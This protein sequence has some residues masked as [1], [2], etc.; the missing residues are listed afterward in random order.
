MATLEVTRGAVATSGDYERYLEIDGRRYSHIVSP[1]TGRPVQG[2][3]GVSVFAEECVVAGSATTIAMLMEERGPAWL[4][5]VSLPHVWMDRDLHVGGT[6][7]SMAEQASPA[8][9]R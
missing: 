9:R 5:E 4:E 8:S 6:Y 7:A 1:R 2:L 3:A